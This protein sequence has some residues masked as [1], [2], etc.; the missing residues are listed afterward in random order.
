VG[1]FDFS[2]YVLNLFDEW[3]YTSFA[4][5]SLTRALGTPTRP[6]TIGA[7]LRWNFF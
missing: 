5:S 1:Q 3:A 7:V 6:R 2:L 4:S